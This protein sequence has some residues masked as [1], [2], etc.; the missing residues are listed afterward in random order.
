MGCPPH[1]PHPTLPQEAVINGSPLPSAGLPGPAL[2]ALARAPFLKSVKYPQPV[3]QP[4]WA[5]SPSPMSPPG[6]PSVF[7]EMKIST[8]KTHFLPSCQREELPPPPRRVSVPPG[9]CL[10]AWALGICGLSHLAAMCMACLGL[11]SP[12]QPTG[13]LGSSSQSTAVTAAPL[14]QLPIH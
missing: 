14:W 13:L 5:L 2:S 12:V 1:S 3:G 4:S 8:S 9:L 11:C 7:S 10:A 6:I